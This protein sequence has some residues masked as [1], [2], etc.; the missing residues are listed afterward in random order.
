MKLYTNNPTQFP[1]DGLHKMTVTGSFWRDGEDKHELPDRDYFLK[2][3]SGYGPLCINVEHWS[4]DIRYYPYA[5]VDESLRKLS[6]LTRWATDAFSGRVISHYRIFPLREYWVP[7]RSKG[8]HAV[9]WYRWRWA[10]GYTKRRRLPNGQYDSVGLADLCHAT[11]PSLYSFYENREG[12]VRHAEANIKEA[13]KYGKPVIPFLWPRYHDRARPSLR[14]QPIPGDYWRL[15]LETLKSLGVKEVCIWDQA[16]FYNRKLNL[17]L[18][19]ADDEWVQATE[20]YQ[21]AN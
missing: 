18:W 12:W 9:A 4:W 2:K 3:C 20:E 13:R 5:T 14:L 7:Q 17:P 15:Q 8:L 6:T 11:M 10:N 1:L 21:D 16:A 19:T